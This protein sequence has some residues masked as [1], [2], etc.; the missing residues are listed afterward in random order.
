MFKK[1]VVPAF[2]LATFILGACTPIWPTPLPS[3]QPLPLPGVSARPLGSPSGVGELVF[4]NEFNSLDTSVWSRSWFS[5]TNGYSRPINGKESGCYHTDQ[6][7]VSNGVLHLRT[8][9]NTASECRL[10]NGSTAKIKSGIVS[11]NGKREFR[12]GYFEARVSMSGA[13]NWPAWWT[14]GHHQTWPDR[15]EL[16][17]MELL[18]CRKPAWHVHYDS[19]HDGKC[20]SSSAVGWHTYAMRWSPT[21]VDF[22][23]DGTLVGGR[24]VS[25][26]HDHYLILNH[27]VR[28]DYTNGTVVNQD[29]QVD[30]V[31]VWKLA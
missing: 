5:T 12:Y 22:Y 1:R 28:S 30:Y 11:S 17:I 15:G 19:V 21:R 9:A 10:R 25:I 7:T 16:D 18:S 3:P 24:A 23:Y 4:E 6:A 8:A 14:N 31:R 29:M 26:A 27:A 2:A 20:A 13:Y